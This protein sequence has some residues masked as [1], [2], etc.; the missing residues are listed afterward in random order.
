MPG[1]GATE[2]VRQATDLTEKVSV[3]GYRDP[4]LG[5]NKSSCYACSKIDSLENRGGM[6]IK[7]VCLMMRTRLDRTP[8]T[9][10]FTSSAATQ[11]PL[12]HAIPSPVGM[13]VV[14]PEV[15]LLR[16]Y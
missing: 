12:G 9:I 11:R 7:D 2:D 13:A 5:V 15:L 1:T 3:M 6:G 8:A 10:I 4:R 14:G 16:E